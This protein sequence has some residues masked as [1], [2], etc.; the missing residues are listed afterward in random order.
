MR[1][2]LEGFFGALYLRGANS[3]CRARVDALLG[4]DDGDAAALAGAA[5]GAPLGD[6]AP[7]LRVDGPDVVE[8]G[9]AAFGAAAVGADPSLK[10][11]Q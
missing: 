11:R 10:R 4:A 1:R 8:F 2:V 7:R 6:V 9:V 5:C 3:L